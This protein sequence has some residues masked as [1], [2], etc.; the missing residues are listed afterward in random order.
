MPV[1]IMLVTT[2][3]D[4]PQEPSARRNWAPA[5]TVCRGL[6]DRRSDRSL[7]RRVVI[8]FLLAG[9]LVGDDFRSRLIIVRLVVNQF[10][11]TSHPVGQQKVDSIALAAPV[12]AAVEAVWI[13][14]PFAYRRFVIRQDYQS[15]RA[16][17]PVI[18][19]IHRNVRPV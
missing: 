9:R 5:S 10:V 3:A 18:Q 17:E 15:L 6:P 13:A 11:V 4:A 16:V 19:F 14:V 7:G 2:K 1:P 12:I 8:Y